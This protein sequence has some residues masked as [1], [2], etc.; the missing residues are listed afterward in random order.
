MPGILDVVHGMSGQLGRFVMA[1]INWNS[2]GRD[3][4]RVA[5]RV[6]APITLSMALRK[7][8]RFWVIIVVVIVFEGLWPA[9]RLKVR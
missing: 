5:S 6:R 9:L 4:W 2:Y 1:P 3:T 8:G 7:S